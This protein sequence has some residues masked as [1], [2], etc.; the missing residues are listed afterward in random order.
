[1][2]KMLKCPDASG[3]ITGPVIPPEEA[4]HP[5]CLFRACEDAAVMLQKTTM[6]LVCFGL[7]PSRYRICNHPAEISDSVHGSD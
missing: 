7:F 2:L 1:M 3:R 4:P 6:N 5:D